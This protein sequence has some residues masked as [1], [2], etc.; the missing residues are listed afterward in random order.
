LDRDLDN[1][2]RI[3]VVGKPPPRAE[4]AALPL[5]DFGQHNGV[6]AVQVRSVDNVIAAIEAAPEIDIILMAPPDVSEAG[7][8]AA[9][10]AL[11]SAAATVPIVVL[12]DS[13]EP[14]DVL[15]LIDR[16]VSGILR[17]DYSASA[18]IKVLKLVAAGETYVCGSLVRS[19]G[20]L[21]CLPTPSTE[22]AMRK[23]LGNLTRREFE[24][25][26]HLAQ[27]LSNRRIGETMK[28]SEM[29][30][31]LHLHRAFR[32]MGAHNRS[33]AMR[34]ALLHGMRLH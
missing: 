27:G 8:L 10:D 34:I 9:V 31:K 3:L 16:G 32:K 11:H 13:I 4:S 21:A 14:N 5:P 6:A 1:D 18:L 2:I 22:D 15:Q 23:A 28:L 25:I 17:Q 33:D 26:E 7:F 12:S 30:I 24:C 20:K 29:T 19:L